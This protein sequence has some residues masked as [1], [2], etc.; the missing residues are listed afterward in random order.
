MDPKDD[1]LA[2]RTINS[3]RSAYVSYVLYAPFF[4]H[5]SSK[6]ITDIAN[7]NRMAAPTDGGGGSADAMGGEEQSEDPSSKCK[8][9]MRVREI[10]YFVTFILH[11]F[12]NGKCV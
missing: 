8:V 4:T 1:G 7:A 2:L 12:K 11:S 5:Y 3:S 6:E 10:S 9:T